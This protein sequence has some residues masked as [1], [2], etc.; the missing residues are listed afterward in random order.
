MSDLAGL[1]A[2]VRGRVQGVFFRSFVAGK[3]AEL[4]LSGG[5]RNR[6]DGRSVEVVAEGEREA[7]EKL[8]AAL[9][10]GPPA[11]A[12]S[13]VDRVWTEYRGEYRGFSVRY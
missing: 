8:A 13:G 7:L 6:A 2:V 11:A 5:V 10:E 9:A 3:A 1:R 4:G 12:V